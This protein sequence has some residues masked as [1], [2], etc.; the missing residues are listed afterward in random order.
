MHST[1]T[2]LVEVC[3]Y[4]LDNMSEGFLTGA[5]FLDLKKKTFDTVHHEVLIKKLISIGVQGRELDWFSSYLTERYQ[6][7]KVNDHHS[8]KAPVS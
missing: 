7:T 3:D 2:C 6:V 4:L 1:Q 8:N 5:V